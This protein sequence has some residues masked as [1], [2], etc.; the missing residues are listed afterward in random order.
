LL[1]QF[2]GEPN[3]YFKEMLGTH[4]FHPLPKKNC[5]FGFQV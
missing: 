4:H 2:D 3:L 5:D 1:F